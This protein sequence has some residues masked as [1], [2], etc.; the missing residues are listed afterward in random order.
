MQQMV[1]P[2]IA[3]M[4]NSKAVLSESSIWVVLDRGSVCVA[5]GDT[6]K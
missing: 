5:K 3:K 4:A 1:S 2:I 6:D